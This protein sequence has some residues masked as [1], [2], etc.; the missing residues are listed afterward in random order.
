MVKKKRIGNRD[1]QNLSVESIFFNTPFCLIGNSVTL[2]QENGAYAPF[3]QPSYGI[4]KLNLMARTRHFRRELSSTRPAIPS[5][6]H[7]RKERRNS[8]RQLFFPFLLRHTMRIEQIKRLLAIIIALA[9]EKGGVGKTTLTAMFLAMLSILGY[10]VLGV[11]M[12]PQGHLG[13]IWGYHRDTI[14]EGVYDI[15]LKYAP[16]VLRERAPIKRI[17]KK[18]Y[19]DQSGRIF[20]PRK[21]N[22]DTLDVVLRKVHTRDQIEEIITQCTQG[23]LQRLFSF[24]VPTPNE[25]TQEQEKTSGEENTQGEAQEEWKILQKMVNEARAMIQ[26]NIWESVALS[27]DQ[28]EDLKKYTM[29]TVWYTIQQHVN[30]VSDRSQEQGIEGDALQEHLNTVIRAATDGRYTLETWDAT[31]VHI[32]EI[33]WGILQDRLAHSSTGPDIIPINASAGEADYA[34][35]NKH[36]Y[37]GE[38]LRQALAPLADQYDYIL[39]DCPPSIQVLT[40]N[41]LNASS[42]V[43]IPLTPETLNLEGMIGL[44]GVIDQAQA[45]ANPGL[46]VAGLILNKMQGTWRI[47]QQGAKEVRAWKNAERVF[48]TEIKQNAPVVTSLDNQ[49]L[50]VLDQGE[51][52][53]AKAYW[54]LLDELL[55]VVGGPAKEEVAEIAVEIRQLKKASEEKRQQKRM[56]KAATKS[57]TV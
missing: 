33:V 34:L 2:S 35:K 56:Q 13:L 42:Y 22:K 41:A 18:T 27:L 26:E 3:S 14:L 30:E 1:D 15:L 24:D 37:W 40:I 38:Q 9:S 53:S 7:Q 8:K 5:R 20:D 36:Q 19:Y 25:E 55:D 54:L 29:S 48:K 46:K 57:T 10:R 17:I 28:G 11:D 23:N 4:I 32:D 21:P 31:Q 47:H 52:E 45:R 16:N 44:L 12:D 49:S 43:G 50:V 6:V 39:I 51:G